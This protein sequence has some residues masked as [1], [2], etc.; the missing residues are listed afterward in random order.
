[1]ALLLAGTSLLVLAS[2]APD[3]PFFEWVAAALLVTSALE[4]VAG[5]Y[6]PSRGRNGSAHLFAGAAG[7]GFGGFVAALS[8]TTEHVFA[9]AAV[10]LVLGLFCVAN[11]AVRAGDVL[12]SRSRAWPFEAINALVSLVVG[13]V[14]LSS[15]H[16]ATPVSVGLMAGVELLAAG[17]AMTGSAG[18]WT[19]RAARRHSR[20]MHLAPRPF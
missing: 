4:L 6:L 12:V 3:D 19:S 10:T 1:M 13:A 18:T 15:W 5:V 7:L 9:P 2:Q 14:A 17:V 11:G 8:V 20:P 16:V